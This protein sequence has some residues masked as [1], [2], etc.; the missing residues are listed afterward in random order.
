M[1]TGEHHRVNGETSAWTDSPAARAVEISLAQAQATLE[2]G[3]DFAA[4]SVCLA[5]EDQQQLQRYIDCQSAWRRLGSDYLQS[6]RWRQ[7]DYLQARA[8]MLAGW[9]S[10]YGWIGP[11][12]GR[13]LSESNRIRQEELSV[14]MAGLL[15]GLVDDCQ[16]G[17]DNLARLSGS[18]V[19]R[20][21]LRQRWQAAVFSDKPRADYL[22]DWFRAVASRHQPLGWPRHQPEPEFPPGLMPAGADPRP[23]A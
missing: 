17:N 9:F 1:A 14:A 12:A 22:A 4:A 20:Q 2:A 16:T 18:A 11:P 3:G 5:L 7:D 19:V 10:R 23:A 21:R 13:I 6:G 15:D 8:A